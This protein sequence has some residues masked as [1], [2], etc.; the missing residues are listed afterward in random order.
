MQYHKLTK[1]DYYDY[2]KSLNLDPSKLANAQI[3]LKFYYDSSAPY[4]YVPANSINIALYNTHDLTLFKYYHMLDAHG[5]VNCK[6]LSSILSA[7]DVDNYSWGVVYDKTDIEGND[8]SDL[9]RSYYI[10][11]YGGKTYLSDVELSNYDALSDVY[12]LQGNKRLS[13]KYDEELR[14]DLSNDLYYY[15]TLNINYP[16]RAAD[17]VFHGG[18]FSLKETENANILSN[19]FNEY[20]MFI[21]DLDKPEDILSSIGKVDI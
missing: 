15:P 8:L 5:A 7:D 12:I 20:N 6:Y 4:V 3:V 21:I 16:L 17:F 9:M 13:F 19:I 2:W 18:V 1:N 14:F 11:E 10:N